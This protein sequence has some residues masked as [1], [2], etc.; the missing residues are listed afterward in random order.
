DASTATT[1][2]YNSDDTIQSVTD[3][4]GASATYDYSGNN[5]RLVSGISYY[6]P[7]GVAG[8]PNVSFTYDAVSNRTSM[9]DSIGSRTYNYDQLSRMSSETHHF[10]DLAG[11]STGGNY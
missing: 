5:R 1:Y 8:T 7:S 3:A 9:T 2:A 6:A 11:T 4:R 10:N